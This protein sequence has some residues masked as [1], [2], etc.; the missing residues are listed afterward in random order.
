MKIWRL[1]TLV[2]ALLIALQTPAWPTEQA[3]SIGYGFSLFSNGKDSGKIEDGNYDF[4]QAAYLYEKP[5]S[6]RWM[7]LVEPFAAYINRPVEGV[8]VG[9]NLGLKVYP[10]TQHR[11]GF[12]FTMGTGAAYTS[13]KFAEQG[14]HLLFILQGSVGYRYRNFFIEDRWRHY[15]NSNTASPNRSI[16]ANIV[17]LGMYF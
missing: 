12:F 16:N 9:L 3:L 7:L 2:S 5:L 10:F 13:V 8:D 17:V 14:T 4:F 11:S 1:A 6:V 15:S